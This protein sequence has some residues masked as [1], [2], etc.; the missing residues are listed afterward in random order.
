[1]QFDA[2]IGSV[3]IHAPG[4]SDPLAVDALRMAAIQLCEKTS[5]WHESFTQNVRTQD[6][7]LD[8]P[9]QSRAVGIE[10]VYINGSL[11]SPITAGQADLFAQPGVP[12]G[13][14][15]TEDNV[16]RL[17]PAPSDAV[18]L[19]VDVILAPTYTATSIPDDL[20]NRCRKALIY[21][22]LAQ[23]LIVPGQAWTNPTLAVAYQQMHEQE[24]S[25]ISVQDSR[26]RVRSALRVRSSY[27]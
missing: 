8:V 17:V 22:A 20:A 12:D 2:L 15:R 23:L 11:I 18:S 19:S 14:Y 10:R 3:L 27:F 16:L 25:H 7:E 1:M 13:Y 9:S 5:A 26:S 24:T 21:G 4:A 6:I